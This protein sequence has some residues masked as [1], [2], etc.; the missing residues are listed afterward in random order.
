MRK[1]ILF[2]ILI[3]GQAIFAGPQDTL[4]MEFVLK[5]D[6]KV[7]RYSDYGEAPQIAI[8]I[9]QPG[10]NQVRTLL[11]TRRTAKG[12]WVGKV[13]C[14]VSLPYWVS[15]YGIE[16]GKSNLPGPKNPVPDAVSR[17]TPKETLTAK[18]RVPAG[19]E[20]IYYIEMN[21]SG[22]Y[23]RDFPSMIDGVG[24][25][26]QGNGQPSLVYMGK[27]KTQPGTAGIPELVGRTDQLDPVQSLITDLSGI[28][29]AKELFTSI[30]ISIRE[31]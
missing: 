1:I 4:E 8:W 29:N 30:R 20:L 15:R 6:P 13:E 27:I 3:W 18:T 11:V 12:E 24:P 9:E 23:N 16:S 7:Y 25:D 17:A 2:L 10:K 28:T 14:P 22:D 21:V 19:I 31:N 5:L 26:P